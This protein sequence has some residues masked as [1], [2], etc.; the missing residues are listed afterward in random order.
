[1]ADWNVLSTQLF[2]WQLIT[3]KVSRSEQGMKLHEQLCVNFHCFFLACPCHRQ[4]IDS[5][6]MLVVQCETQ[7]FLTVILLRA[8]LENYLIPQETEQ[9]ET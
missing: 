6:W 1:M 2:S 4:K 3:C 8:E 5:V 9:G 7:L